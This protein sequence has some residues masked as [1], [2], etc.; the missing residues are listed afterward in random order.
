MNSTHAAWLNFLGAAAAAIYQ[1]ASVAP[2][3]PWVA[4]A[5]LGV[6]FVLHGTLPDAPPGAGL[7][8]VKSILAVLLIPLGLTLG[9][10]TSSTLNPGFINNPG[11]V[12]ADMACWGS[13]ASTAVLAALAAKGDTSSSLY[14]NAEAVAVG[15]SVMCPS[16]AGGTGTAPNAAKT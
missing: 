10:C 11:A 14:H 5:L 9:S 12:G 8:G 7:S 15:L 6:N 2:L 16:A 1:V 3:P 13:Q 4:P